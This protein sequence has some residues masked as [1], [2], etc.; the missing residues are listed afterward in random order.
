ME[1]LF[2]IR[3]KIAKSKYNKREENLQINVKIIFFFL[4]NMKN[5]R[6]KIPNKQ[7][8]K[9]KTEKELKIEKANNIYVGLIVLLSMGF[10]YHHYH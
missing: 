10:V 7:E 3:R 8:N 9:I 5:I 4:V 1:I 6:K 2:R